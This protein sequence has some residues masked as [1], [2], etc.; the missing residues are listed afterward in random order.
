MRRSRRLLV[1]AGCASAEVVRSHLD[2]FIRQASEE[3]ARKLPAFAIRELRA[4]GR[5]GDWTTG[6]VRLRCG[7]CRSDRIVPFTCQSRICPSCVARRAADTACWPVD[8]VLRP[9]I[10]WRQ[11][12]I[13]FPRELAIGLCFR[14]SLADA[15][16]RLCMRVLFEH[17]RARAPRDAAGI[18]RPG[19]IVCYFGRPPVPTSRVERKVGGKVVVNLKRAGG[20]VGPKPS[21]G[22]MALSATSRPRSKSASCSGVARSL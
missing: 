3:S 11:V 17:Q 4:S 1:P 5:C 19:G 7:S 15:G 2:D 8:R 21:L 18:A 20:G 22:P 10:R 6:F 16:V 14:A 13:T 9:E 12:V